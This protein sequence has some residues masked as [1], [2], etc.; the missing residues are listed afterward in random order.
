MAFVNNMTK[1]INKIERRLGTHQYNLPE[2]MNK[3]MWHT[4]IEDDTIPTFSRTFPNKIE[5]ELG[6]NQRSTKIKDTYIIDESLVPGNI[7][8]IGIKDLSWKNMTNNVY[9]AAAYGIYGG[10]DQYNM[11]GFQDI[12]MAQMGAD[13]AS[14][15]N[16]GLFL[17]FK[18]PNEV[19]VT[20]SLNR[21]MGYALQTF[22]IEVF[23]EHAPNLL[24]ID[25]TKM[26]VFENLATADVATYLYGELKAYDD[27]PTVFGANVDLKLSDIQDKAN[28]REQIVE[29]LKENMVSPS[30]YNQPIIMSV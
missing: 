5:I 6:P 25:P 28:S 19:K 12:G 20:N 1:L 24:T 7:K 29:Y 16:C 4:I 14:M 3:S 30:N 13:L 21:D 9:A 10:Y 22:P 2:C 26:E 8:I 17:E 11:Y 18:A 15:F 23:I 27:L